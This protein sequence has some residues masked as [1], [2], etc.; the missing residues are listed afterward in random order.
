MHD[1]AHSARGR[2]AFKWTE[3]DPPRMDRLLGKIGYLFQNPERQLFEDTVRDEVGFSLKRMGVSAREIKTRV[4]EALELCHV[5][6][7]KDRSPLTL[8]FGEQHRVALASVMAPQPQNPHAGRT[9][10]GA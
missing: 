1:R 4:A 6:H 10:C 9:F 2:P 8:S 7:L 3:W 5:A